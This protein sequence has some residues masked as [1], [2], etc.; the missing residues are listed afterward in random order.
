M[1]VRGRSDWKGMNE[2]ADFISNDIC[3]HVRSMVPCGY[4]MKDKTPY[5]SWVG[6]L[7]GILLPGAAHF[8][9]GKRAVGLLWY[10]GLSALGL[11][12]L[13]IAAIPGAV[14][15][16]A[17]IL[18][19]CVTALL[20]IVM[21]TQS[22]RSVRRIGISGW[23]AVIAVTLVLS[24][25]EN[26]LTE[27]CIHTVKLP[28]GAMQ[29]TLRGNTARDMAVSSLGKPGFMSRIVSGSRFRVI[30]TLN[31]GILSG[32][33]EAANPGEIIYRV[34]SDAYTVPRHARLRVDPGSR[35]SK[36]EILWS[37]VVSRGDC[38]M[39]N[40]MSYWFSEP[41]RGDIIVFQTSGIES[42]QPGQ[43]YVKRV[44][45]LP[46]DRV[47]IDPPFLIVND[48]RVT[49][50]KI[51]GAISSRTEG[52]DGFQLVEPYYAAGL[53]SKP[54]D[55]FLLG[56]DEYFVLGDNTRNSRDSRFWGAVPR[57]NIVGKVTRV[58]WPF[59]RI[60]ALDGK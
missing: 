40:L 4:Q 41:Q 2:Q 31:G 21:V 34:G 44:T 57:E 42:L 43:L 1:E 28:T 24:Y 52:Y 53:L 58:Y 17:A 15:Y 11:L 49:E 7:L 6:V 14:T 13:L 37:G 25:A 59:T 26:F 51:F 3:G 54:S 60:N 18:L 35:V 19:F 22:Y 45:G 36:G 48:E 38:L 29:P 46:G 33:F 56:E 47:R 9:A 30:R 8:L 32:P 20:W 12:V 55:E 27:Q 23:L 16:I 39:V 10:V 5:R 50:P